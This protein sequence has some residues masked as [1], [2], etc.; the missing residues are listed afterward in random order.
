MAII[1]DVSPTLANTSIP[2]QRFVTGRMLS[3]DSSD[4][5]TLVFAGSLSSDLWIS[6]NG[7]VSWSQL[8]WDQPAEG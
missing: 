2:A 6:E 5:G 4:D 8:R 3:M 1:S 7:G